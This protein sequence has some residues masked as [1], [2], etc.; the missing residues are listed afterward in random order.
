MLLR[1]RGYYPL[2]IQAECTLT[3]H[4]RVYPLASRTVSCCGEGYTL[5]AVKWE[6][7]LLWGVY[8]AWSWSAAAAGG[9]TPRYQ[10]GCCCCCWG[11]YTSTAYF[12][13]AWVD[14]SK[15]HTAYFKRAWVDI[16]KLQ[17]TY[18]CP[19]NF[20]TIHICLSTPVVPFTHGP[21]GPL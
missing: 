10:I 19:Q 16:S 18:V 12:K 11:G 7:V 13:R 6:L 20:K 14:I 15:L 1:W 4:R 5:E 9:V 3:A 21:K 8:L 2:R 17:S